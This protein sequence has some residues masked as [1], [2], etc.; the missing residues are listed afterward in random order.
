MMMMIYP[1]QLVND[2]NSWGWRDFKID[3]VCGFT[4]GYV[5]QIR[6]GNIVEMSHTRAVRLY[7]FWEEEAASRGVQIPPYGSPAA[8]PTT[9]DKR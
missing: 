2:L 4:Q 9:G 3:T 7:N 1:L 5:N 6:R 8:P